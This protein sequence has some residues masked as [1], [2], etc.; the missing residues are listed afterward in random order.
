VPDEVLEPYVALLRERGVRVTTA[1]RAV[2]VALVGSGSHVTAEEVAARVQRDH[3]DIHL[4]TVYR[5]L[6]ALTDLG[7][8][9]HVH[10]GHGRAVYHLAGDEHQHL[11]CERCG[12]V[13]EV[14]DELLADLAGRV[15]AE[16][17]FELRPRHFALSGRCEACRG[18]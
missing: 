11:V 10:L 14:P 3:P 16:Y 2:L 12:A 17:R 8:I 15:R 9:E 7:V 5:N 13:I 18:S 4:S 6:E 1:R